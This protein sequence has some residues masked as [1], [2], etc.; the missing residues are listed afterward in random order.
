MTGMCGKPQRLMFA[1]STWCAQHNSYG[2][3]PVNPVS[4]VSMPC[5][6]NAG[7]SRNLVR[8]YSI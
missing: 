2:I 8:R 5:Y 7:H 6:G 3:P 4:Q 1:L